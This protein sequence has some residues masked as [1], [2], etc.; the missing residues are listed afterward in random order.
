M[1]VLCNQVKFNNLLTRYLIKN[2]LILSVT[3]VL[4][5]SVIKGRTEHIMC[6]TNIISHKQVLPVEIAH[7]QMHTQLLVY[8][9]STQAVALVE[10]KS[11]GH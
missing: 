10:W 6:N 8:R 5:M 3:K 9:E 4:L 7:M 1:L 11:F 2:F